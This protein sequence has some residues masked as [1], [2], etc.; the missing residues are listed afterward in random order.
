MCTAQL[1]FLLNV[2]YYVPPL[3]AF[4]DTDLLICLAERTM[5]SIYSLYSTVGKCC[6]IDGHSARCICMIGS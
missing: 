6:T 4:I 3:I 5:L 2:V 1:C